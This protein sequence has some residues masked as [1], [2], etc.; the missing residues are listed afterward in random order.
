MPFLA[1][2]KIV[3]T[4]GA[5]GIGLATA[6]A[7]L[8]EGAEVCITGR[9]APRLEEARAR[10]QAEA[11]GAVLTQAFD[12]TDQKACAS[13]MDAVQEQ[14]GAIDGLVNNAGIYRAAPFLQLVA[15]DFEALFQANVMGAV[16]LLQAVLPGMVARRTGRV[17]NIGSSAG[18]WGSVNQSA[19]NTSKHALVGLTRCVA[20]EMAGHG[21]TVNAVCPGLVETDMA[22]RLLAS[23]AEFNGTPPQATLAATLARIPLGRAV[24]PREIGGLVTYLMSPAAAG[25]TGQSILYDGGMLQI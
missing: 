1:N 10:L 4:G 8:Q 13:A 23:Q 21:I 24:Q 3:V 19:Y 15:E 2:M 5:T 12:V 14:W 20:L 9:N 18:K 16:N 7:L 6:R 17:V 11:G 25:M 22:E